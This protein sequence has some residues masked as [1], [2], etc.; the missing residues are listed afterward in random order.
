MTKT[1]KACLR[2]KPLEQF[3]KRLGAI[4]L[5]CKQCI[6]LGQ[7][8]YRVRTLSSR[9]AY[10]RNY[11]KSHIAENIIRKAKVRAKEKG[12]DFN[13]TPADIA[14]PEVCPIM[15]IKLCRNDG[16]HAA[17]SYSLDRIDSR[18]G[19]VTGNVQVISNLA[20]RL[21]S[22]ATP[23]QLLLLAQWINLQFGRRAA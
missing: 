20:N 11:G 22:D 17:D 12:W 1:C 13:L 7:R 14:I 4:Q 9:R 5:R 16:Q 23:E 6:N 8:Q 15:G 3:G 10:W 19:Y 18:V 2:D 21:K